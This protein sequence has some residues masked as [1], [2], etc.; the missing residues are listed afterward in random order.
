MSGTSLP[1]S[2]CWPHLPLP[3]PRTT[4]CPGTSHSFLSIWKMPPLPGTSWPIA[5]GPCNP[6]DCLHLCFLCAW[7]PVLR[8]LLACGAKGM[9]GWAGGEQNGPGQAPGSLSALP[10]SSAWA[11]PSWYLQLPPAIQ[12][13]LLSQFIMDLGGW[14]PHQVIWNSTCLRGLGPVA[15]AQSQKEASQSCWSNLEGRY[16][17]GTGP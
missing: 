1:T 8:C 10:S 11:D 15:Q 17:T 3:C 2:H 5:S 14:L 13:C 16:P 12:S 6:V 7:L 4:W 9:G